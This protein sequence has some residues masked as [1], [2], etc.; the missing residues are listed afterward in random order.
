MPPYSRYAS[1]GVQKA[2]PSVSNCCRNSSSSN[3]SSSCCCCRSSSRSIRIF[4]YCMPRFR[5]YSRLTR[6]L[7]V[8]VVIVVVVV[9]AVV[10]VVVEEVSVYLFIACPLTLGMLLSVYR[11]LTC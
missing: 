2:D 3:S 6:W 11:R 1:E 5:V 8:V 10:V 9:V 7:V 4:V